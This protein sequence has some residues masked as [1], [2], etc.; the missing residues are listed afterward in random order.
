MKIYLGF[1]DTSTLVWNS[2]D[3]NFGY[4]ANSP[5]FSIELDPGNYNYIIT[6]SC[7]EDITGGFTITDASSFG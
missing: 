2:D 1:A 3:P 6:N 7:G 5:K 4:T